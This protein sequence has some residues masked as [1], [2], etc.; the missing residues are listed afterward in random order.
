MDAPADRPP[1][2]AGF[3]TIIL[4]DLHVAD[5]AEVDPARPLWKRFKQRDLFIDDQVRALVEALL[6]RVGEDAELIL[7]GDIF[8][9]DSVMAIPRPAPFDTSWLERR[10]GLH[11]EEPKS[12]FKMRRILADHPVFVGALRRWLEAGHRLVFVVGNH[13]I[14]LLWPGVQAQLREALGPL[15]EG[16]MR[17]C[18]WVYLS[19][20]DTLVQHGN[21]FDAYCVCVDPVWPTVRRGGVE[22]LRLPF[23]NLAER[24]ML[25]GMGLFNPHVES[26]FI[27]SLPQYVR[28]FLRTVLPV[29]PLLG[30]TWLWSAIATLYVTLREGFLP[31]QRDP[32]A[33]EAR[34]AEMARKAQ[35][36]VGQLV[37]L[38]AL[39]V[40]SAVFRP[41]MLM[42]EL[43]LDRALI[44]AL[45]VAASFQVV[46]VYNVFAPLSPAWALV[47]FALLLPPFIFYARGVNSDVQNTEAALRQRLGTALQIAR[48]RR[49]VVGHTHV[50]Q[51]TLRPEGELIN[52]GT[53][54]PA[55]HDVE[56]TRP[57]GR[58]CLAWIRPGEGG[59]QA[60]L[61]A[62]EAGGLQAL[63]PT[64][65]EEERPGLL[66]AMRRKVGRGRGSGE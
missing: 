5:A 45:L 44:L 15:A 18:E 12:R 38:Q 17:V 52:T 62:W 22:V 58:K 8:D 20:S 60:R 26:S 53:W 29:Q 57:F 63:P 65:E 4:S 13:D 55:F 14:E 27:M 36:S 39:Q 42:R 31:A 35:L 37:A 19:G 25:N 23:G 9:F 50:E 10:R 48:V 40:H 41:W 61:F 6:P 7:A 56:C 1:A 2:P 54:S 43:W 24:I 51:H 3:H 66:E 16:R 21:Q 33:M 11:A 49:L 47:I 59:R 32:V 30:F 64:R 34:L 46:T 28:F